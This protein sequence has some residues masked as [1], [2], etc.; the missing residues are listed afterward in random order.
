MKAFTWD[1]PKCGYRMTIDLVAGERVD[2]TCGRCRWTVGQ[3]LDG[4][5]TTTPWD[6]DPQPDSR[7]KLG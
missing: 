1:C 6:E 5:Q 3:E 2:L 7:I 4:Y